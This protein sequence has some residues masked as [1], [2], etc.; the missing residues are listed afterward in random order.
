MLILGGWI[1]NQYGED[2]QSAFHYPREL[3]IADHRSLRTM[4]P[5]YLRAKHGVAASSNDSGKFIKTTSTIYCL[6]KFTLQPYITKTIQ[7]TQ[8]KLR[9]IQSSSF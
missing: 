8:T 1:E 2:Q 9:A 7:A 6:L 5:H 4:Q 3:S